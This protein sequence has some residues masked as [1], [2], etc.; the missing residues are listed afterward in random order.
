MKVF[1]TC[2][3]RVY[4]VASK[5]QL[6]LIHYPILTALLGP[7]SWQAAVIKKSVRHVSSDIKNDG[8]INIRLVYCQI[9]L[10]VDI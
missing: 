3:T 7:G 2:H 9:N 6:F 1:S 8:V 4:T 10:K 5:K